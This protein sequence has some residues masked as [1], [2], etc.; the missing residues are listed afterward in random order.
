MTADNVK[1]LHQVNAINESH[2]MATYR[3][4]PPNNIFAKGVNNCGGLLSTV[5]LAVESRVLLKFTILVPHGLIKGVMR[6]LRN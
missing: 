3:N 5:R 4:S 2:E 6:F 1:S